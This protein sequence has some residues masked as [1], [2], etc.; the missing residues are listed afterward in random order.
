VCICGI[1]FTLRWLA[2]V[3]VTLPS[4]LKTRDLLTADRLM[5]AGPF[6]AT[7]KAFLT[8]AVAFNG[9]CKIV[10][11]DPLCGQRVSAHV[12]R[13]PCEC[14]QFPGDGTWQPAL[15]LIAVV[16][17]SLLVP[18]G[19]D[20]GDERPSDSPD[21]VESLTGSSRMHIVAILQANRLA[22]TCQ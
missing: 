1:R 18:N 16:L 20:K 21:C 4:A 11:R 8:G 15:Q 22:G 17:T 13:S 10:T 12:C 3:V 6:H 14:G 7:G 19:H 5:D 9:L 2:C